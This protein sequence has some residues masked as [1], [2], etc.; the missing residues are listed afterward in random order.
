MSS[1]VLR[2]TLM[3]LTVSA[4]VLI[5]CT[6]A[7]VE[8]QLLDY[9]LMIIGTARHTD[10]VDVEPVEGDISDRLEVLL[11]DLV[12]VEHFWA[13]TRQF[14]KFLCLSVELP[15]SP[16]LWSLYIRVHDLGRSCWC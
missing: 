13:A 2:R 4:C 11:L 16:H 5:A 12:K 3:R 9:F 6:H 7:H 15:G 14:Y 8:R 10:K 1:C